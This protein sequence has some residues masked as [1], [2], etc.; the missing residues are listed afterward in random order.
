MDSPD[1]LLREDGVDFERVLDRAL[2]SVEIRTAL[3]R[4][5]GA[6]SAEQLRTRALQVSTEISASANAQYEEYLR[7]RMAAL[8]RAPR[9][10]EPPAADLRAG[11]GRA[12]L[13][14]VLA[15]LVPVLA[16]AAA[17]VFLPLGY[18]LR[19]AA[20][21]SGLADCLV[22]AGWTS[23]VVSA[24]VALSGVVKVVVAAAGNRSTPGGAYDLDEDPGI[25]R[26]RMLWHEALR[27]RGVMPFL[28]RQL[29]ALAADGADPGPSGG[30]PRAWA[31]GDAGTPS[32]NRMC[33]RTG[34]V[35]DFGAPFATG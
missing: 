5:A 21:H 8:R 25:E 28:R 30:G 19:I 23:L 9:R 15:V 24:V 22:T 1:R 31:V 17:V 10:S 7:L 16:A 33:S 29:E 3:S 13:V 27:E 11:S 34:D 6:V 32:A 2:N 14:A 35:R 26:A 20:G 4:T 12:E 18:G